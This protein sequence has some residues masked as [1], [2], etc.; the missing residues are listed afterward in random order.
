MKLYLG[1]PYIGCA[2]LELYWN[3]PQFVHFSNAIG[4]SL[5]M[6]MWQFRMKAHAPIIDAF[7]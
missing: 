7:V 3:S 6:L 2:V 5:A 4:N 1:T